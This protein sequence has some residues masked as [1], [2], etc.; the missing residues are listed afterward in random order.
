MK[1]HMLLY[2]Q[3]TAG[4]NRPPTPSQSL[5]LVACQG[6]LPGVTSVESVDSRPAEAHTARAFYSG[7]SGPLLVSVS[8]SVCL[9]LPSARAPRFGF[10]RPHRPPKAIPN[11]NNDHVCFC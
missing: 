9:W 11:T 1:F 8:L 5:P 7:G 6:R 2:A 3:K 10:G 4:R